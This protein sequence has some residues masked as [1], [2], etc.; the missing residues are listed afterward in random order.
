VLTVAD[1]VLAAPPRL[2]DVRAL[3]VDG[4]SGSGKSSFATR[5]AAEL[6]GRGVRVCVLATDDI[7][8]WADP[9]GWWPRMVTGVL[10]PVRAGRAGRYRRTEWITGVPRPGGFVDVPVPEV[11]ILEGVTSGRVSVRDRMSLLVWVEV[12]DPAVRLSSAVARDGPDSR[13]D[14]E[15]WQEFERGWFAVDTPEAV[16]DIRLVGPRPELLTPLVRVVSDTSG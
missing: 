15:N 5:L 11:L 14:L 7:A 12:T 8:T 13:A 2:G 16:A 9:A 3:A 4:P 6:T 10:D 1:A